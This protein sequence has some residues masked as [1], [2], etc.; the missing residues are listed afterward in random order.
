MLGLQLDEDVEEVAGLLQVLDAALLPV[1][2]NVLDDAPLHEGDLV[3]VDVLDGLDRHVLVVPAADLLAEVA[4]DHALHR[5]KG[6][7]NRTTQNDPASVTAAEVAP[8]DSQRLRK[9]SS[10]T[11]I[12][13]QYSPRVIPALR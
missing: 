11:A 4:H 3:G 10:R 7:A 13:R 2:G 6:Q 12:S 5:S 1:P 8:S 9:S